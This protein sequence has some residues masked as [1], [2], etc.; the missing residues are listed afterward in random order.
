MEHCEICSQSSDGS[1]RRTTFMGLSSITYEF[2]PS[3]M[4]GNSIPECLAKNTPNASTRI[5]R[6]PGNLSPMMYNIN[7]PLN[8]RTKI[9]RL[10]LFIRLKSRIAAKRV[11][12]GVHQSYLAF[13]KWHE[14]FHRRLP[15]KRSCY[16]GV[17]SRHNSS[18]DL[19][20]A[21]VASARAV[22]P[23]STSSLK[24][25]TLTSLPFA[26]SEGSCQGCIG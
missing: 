14:G 19:I 23:A 17:K 22:R 18:C 26:S 9:F 25:R 16:L 8:P 20:N 7:Q 2:Q 5:V 24:S 13:S 3:A 15:D 11:D 12:G 10:C 21:P 1:P 6:L 4:V